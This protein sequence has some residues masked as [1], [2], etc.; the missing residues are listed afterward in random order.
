MANFNFQLAEF[1]NEHDYK[2]IKGMKFQLF[3]S[4]YRLGERLAK[5]HRD[6][7]YMVVNL[8]DGTRTKITIEEKGG[9]K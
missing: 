8:E 9:K 2:P 7:E 1:T 6:T 4:A 5:I 3:R